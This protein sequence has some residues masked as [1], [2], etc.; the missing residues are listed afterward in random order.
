M[1]K[2]LIKWPGGKAAEIDKILPH[3]PDFE[4]YIEPFAGGAA[5]FFYL[6][7]EKAVLNDTSKDLMEFYR[8]L[9]TEDPG[10]K[11]DLLLYRD[12]FA[13]LGHLCGMHASHLRMLFDI[14]VSADAEGTDLETL[15]IHE[16]LTREIAGDPSVLCRLMPEREEFLRVM[17]DSVGDKLWRTVRNHRK[18]P[19][20]AEDIRD[21]LITGFTSGYYL[22]FRDVFNRIHSGKLETSASYRAANFYF[23]REYCYGSMFRYNRRGEFNI[24]YGGVSYNKKDF[25]AKIDRMYREEVLSLLGRTQLCCEDF[26]TFV[27]RLDLSGKDFL[28]LDPPYDT[29]FSDYEGKSFGQEDH[30]RLAAMLDRTPAKFLL[31]IKNTDFI[32]KLYGEKFRILHFDNRYA[33]NMRSRNDRDAEHLIITNLPE[34]IVSE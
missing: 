15:A 31:V 27:N 12:S 1:L 28:F 26:E 19:F 20:P 18:R 17:T 30:R 32:S 23:V 6:E 21:N 16:H 22:Y 33:Y 13:A 25:G 7:P 9:Q 5:L 8:M 29:D 24:P 4:R 11:E 14:C 10:M 2:P 34:V 3:I